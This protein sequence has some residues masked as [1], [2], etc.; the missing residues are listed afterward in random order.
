MG[1]AAVVDVEDLSGQGERGESPWITC[2]RVRQ[3]ECDNGAIQ[4][5][6]ILLLRTGWDRLYR[7]GEAGHAYAVAPLVHRQGP[8]WPAPHA[9]LITYLCERGVRCLGIDA[10][11]MGA[12]HDGAP[13]HYAGLSRGMRYVEMLTGLGQLPPRGAFFMFLPV[14]LAQSTGAPGRAIAILPQL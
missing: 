10:P 8:G 4:K 14:K 11:S 5:G 3:W 12:A 13:V 2:E 9:E 1:P 7:Q 6:E